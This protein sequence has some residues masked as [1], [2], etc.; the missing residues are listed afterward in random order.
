MPMIILVILILL[1]LGG[2]ALYNGLVRRRN[3][4][5]EGWSGI[6]VQLK[7]R[8]DLVPN[9]INTVKGY[10][11]HE[12]E[13]F[14]KV[15]DARKEAIQAKGVSP[16]GQAENALTQ[17]IRSLFAVAENY[18]DLKASANFLELQKSLSSVEDEIQL[19]R[20][21]YNGTVRDL[22]TT[23]QSFPA[24]LFARSLGFKEAEFFEIELATERKTPEVNF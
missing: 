8:Y 14:E 7:R 5:Q 16:Q 6:D 21:Y 18:P 19:A 12:K 2:I 23:I 20:R 13:I 24:V 10:G 3:L 15:A 17:G 1:A 4:V 11:K 9:L 22:N